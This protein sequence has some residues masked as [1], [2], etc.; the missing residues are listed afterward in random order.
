[1]DFLHKVEAIVILDAEGN[2]VFAKYYPV[3][4]EAAT[5]K[6]DVI[7]AATGV[8]ATPEK[9][10][11]LEANIHSKTRDP[12]RATCADGD[13]MIVDGHTVL[14][15]MEPELTFIVIGGGEEN[16]MVLNAVVQCLV[17]SLQHVLKVTNLDKRTLLEKYDVL[18]LVVDEMI[19]DG[20]ILETSSSSIVGDVAPFE[21]ESSTDGAKKAVSTLTKLL[22][23]NLM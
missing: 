4:V 13:I 20:I 21:V 11:S 1:M 3:V 12:K 17:E 14:T 5:K 18:L 9:Q 2:R 23:N 7:D 6:S 16:E 8:W 10:A 19:D 15:F 22:K